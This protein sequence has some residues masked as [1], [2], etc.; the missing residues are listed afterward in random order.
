MSASFISIYPWYNATIEAPYE[1]AYEA[2]G[3]NWAKY[4]VVIGLVSSAATSVVALGVSVPRYLFA[5][6]R[7]GLIMR[8][9]SAVNPK[10]KV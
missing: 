4:V 8:Q 3:W 9:L 10:N 1:I 6:A 5:M 7:D 2:A